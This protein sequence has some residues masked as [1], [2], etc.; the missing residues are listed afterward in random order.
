MVASSS[1]ESAFEIT[2]CIRGYHVYPHVWDAALSETLVHLRKATN[3]KYRYALVVEKSGTIGGCT[4][5]VLSVQEVV[6]LLSFCLGATY[7]SFQDNY[8]Q[9]T[10]SRAMGSPA[11]MTVA[12]RVMEGVKDTA[13]ITSNIDIKFWKRYMDDT[14]EELP[15]S[16]CEAFLGHL[17]L[18]KPTIRSTLEQELEGNYR[19]WIFSESTTQMG[20]FL[21]RCIEKQPTWTNIWI[22]IHSTHWLISWR[23]PV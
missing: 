19:S 18:A 3:E 11:S 6:K 10:S 14:C 15:A 5:D 12:N 17:N 23:L 2:Y 16:K 8:Y 1:T 21:P 22:L 13:L 9:Q 20:V 7:M 4:N